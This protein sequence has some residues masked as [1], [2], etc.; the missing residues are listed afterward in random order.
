MKWLEHAQKLIKTE[1]LDPV[2]V[3]MSRAQIPMEMK[4][5]FFTALWMFYDETTAL[6]LSVFEG[7]DFWRQALKK[8]ET[9]R[10]ATERR[11]FRGTGGLRCL[12]SMQKFVGS[13]RP[14]NFTHNLFAPTYMGVKQKVEKYLWGFGDYFVWKIADV[15]DR[16]FGFA[17]DFDEAYSYLPK[18]AKKGFLLIEQ[19]AEEEVGASFGSLEE[20]ARDCVKYA[21]QSGLMAPPSY[22]RLVT[23][24]EIETVACSW[25]KI[26]SGSDEF[27]DIPLLRKAI[28][29]S[30]HPLTTQL[31]AALPV[32]M[33]ASDSCNLFG[34]L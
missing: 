17:C 7:P 23:I 4:G 5:R 29:R 31:L 11:H 18:L 22:D 2:Y 25:R 10:R 13:E 3:L 32:R 14:E 1:E 8:Y 20:V 21:Q 33:T 34:E 12:E 15:Q 26:N 24:Q 30:K 9:A 6:E 19:Q 27:K 16:V 28:L